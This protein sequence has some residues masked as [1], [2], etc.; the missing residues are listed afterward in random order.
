[1]YVGNVSQNIRGLLLLNPPN[2]GPKGGG[3]YRDRHYFSPILIEKTI[4]FVYKK[5][6]QVCERCAP[7]IT[8]TNGR[9]KGDGGEVL[10]NS[11]MV[12]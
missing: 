8:L 12:L 2:G 9:P 10:G 11:T 1:M 4:F 7:N 6:P 5:Y 3:R